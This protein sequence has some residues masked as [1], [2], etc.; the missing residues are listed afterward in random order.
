MMDSPQAQAEKILARSAYLELRA[1]SVTQV[2]GH[3][4]ILEGVV[5][6]FHM[7]QLAQQTILASLLGI[8]IDNRLRVEAR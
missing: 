7:K 6:S 4:L 5:K 8:Q 3:V 1:V 2:N